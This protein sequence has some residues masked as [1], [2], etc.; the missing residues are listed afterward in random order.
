MLGIG[1]FVRAHPN[2][3]KDLI[4]QLYSFELLYNV[5]KRVLITIHFYFKHDQQ[6]QAFF[7]C[8][9]AIH[10]SHLMT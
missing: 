10:I 4:G 3:L 8:L 1:V 9:F 5:L 6:D 7:L 2:S